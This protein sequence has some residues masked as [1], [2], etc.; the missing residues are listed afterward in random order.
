MNANHLRLLTNLEYESKTY[1]TAF[2]IEFESV[3]AVM[4][5]IY[6]SILKMVYIKSIILLIFYP[7]VQKVKYD[8]KNLLVC[9]PPTSSIILYNMCILHFQSRFRDFLIML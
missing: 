8:N 2:S 7:K 6:R 4:W 9:H 3:A 1:Y 5:E